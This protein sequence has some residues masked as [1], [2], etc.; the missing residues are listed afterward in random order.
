MYSIVFLPSFDK[1]SV[2]F[3]KRILKYVPN[4]ELLRRQ[5][6]NHGKEKVSWYLHPNWSVETMHQ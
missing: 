1:L 4:M 6:C 3:F 5:K 2:V